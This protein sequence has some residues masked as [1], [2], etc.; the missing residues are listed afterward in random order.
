MTLEVQIQ[1]IVYSCVFGMT[2]SLFFNLLY[3]Y[4]FHNKKIIKFISTELFIII[5][6]II[7]FTILRKIN[8]GIVTYYFII[9]IIIGFL[10][11]NRK[12]KLIRTYCPQKK[13]QSN[14]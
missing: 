9:M 11:G 3:K 5:S 12:T 6:L 7:Y 4:L 8:Y 1:S 13:E 10:I 2:I 14:S